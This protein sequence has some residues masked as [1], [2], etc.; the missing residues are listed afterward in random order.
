MINVYVTA[1]CYAYRT[2]GD[3]SPEGFADAVYDNFYENSN[4]PATDD[5]CIDASPRNEEEG[6]VYVFLSGTYPVLDVHSVEELLREG[7][8][9]T[10]ELIEKM[11]DSLV[12]D[13]TCGLTWDTGYD[14][15]LRESDYSFIDSVEEAA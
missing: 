1:T 6:D 3:L 12:R 10:S 14:L 7:T 2:E 5:W 11:I 13:I 15:E 4:L 8:P 9:I